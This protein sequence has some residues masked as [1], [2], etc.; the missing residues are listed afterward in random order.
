M[1][2]LLL[3]SP[4]LLLTWPAGGV[5]GASLLFSSSPLQILAPLHPATAL[6]L[7]LFPEE[8]VYVYMCVGGERGGGCMCVGERGGEG[9]CVWGER[10]GE[11]GQEEVQHIMCEMRFY[12]TYTR[13]YS[14]LKNPSPLLPPLTCSSLMSFLWCRAWAIFSFTIC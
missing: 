7:A 8:G 11:G 9:V 2:S 13:T 10:G 14:Y 6:N 3:P 1:F 12:T 4:S 5:H